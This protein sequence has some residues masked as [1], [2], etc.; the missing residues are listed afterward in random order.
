MHVAQLAER[1]AVA[2]KV[3]GS[4]PLVHPKDCVTERPGAALQK[5]R[6]QSDSDRSLQQGSSLMVRPLALDQVIAGSNPAPPSIVFKTRSSTAEQ[7]P[8]ELLVG[9]SN[10]PA[11]SKWVSRPLWRRGGL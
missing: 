4:N 5:L 11:S 2:Q 7:K 8:L 10:P 1:L 9:G 3:G 6:S